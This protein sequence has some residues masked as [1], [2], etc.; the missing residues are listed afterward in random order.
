MAWE[1][2]LRTMMK[3]GG[4][5][6]NNSCADGVINDVISG[7]TARKYL[8]CSKAEFESLVEQGLIQAHRD[9]FKR[10]KVSK[11][12]VLDYLQRSQ[13]SDETRLIVNE[14][15]YNEV[16]Q[17][18]C[19]AKTS[20]KIMTANFKRFRLKPTD[21]QGSN[22]NDGTP[23][24][25]Y[26]IGKSVQGVSVQIICSK[27][28]ESFSE[29]WEKYYHQNGDPELFEYMYCIRNHVKAV[30]IDN[31]YA[32]IG[33]ANVTPAGL[34]Q[35]LFSPGNY[36]AGIMTE[37]VELVSAINNFFSSIWDESRCPNCHRY[38]QCKLTTI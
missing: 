27:P 9:E 29:E 31:K 19:S 26:L 34:G 35:G 17:R 37:N 30:I 2:I 18:I 20:I 16:I 36:E 7:L 21:K 38:N 6:K 15:H 33:S 1:D 14:N 13:S 23:F 12:S 24:I 28:S 3:E 5:E 25:E 4:I 10:W 32:Y 8:K 11:R 22:Y